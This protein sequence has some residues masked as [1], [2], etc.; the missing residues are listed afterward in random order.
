[1]VVQSYGEV[2]TL[3]EYLMNGKNIQYKWGKINYRIWGMG[4]CI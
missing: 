3:E 1:M 2:Y 4:G